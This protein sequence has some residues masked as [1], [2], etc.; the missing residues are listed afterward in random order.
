MLEQLTKEQLEEKVRNGEYIKDELFISDEAMQYD[1][2]TNSIFKY[3]YFIIN[4]ETDSRDTS[5]SSKSYIVIPTTG[6]L[7]LRNTSM[8]IKFNDELK[9]IH[10]SEEQGD[11]TG[12]TAAAFSRKI[13]ELL[14]TLFYEAFDNTYKITV[15]IAVMSN[16]RRIKVSLVA[17][18]D[19]VS[20]PATITV[21]DGD[22]NSLLSILK[23]TDGQTCIN[24]IIITEEVYSKDCLGRA[25]ISNYLCN[26]DVIFHTPTHFYTEVNEQSISGTINVGVYSI[27]GYRPVRKTIYVYHDAMSE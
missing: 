26:A 11:F 24:D 12:V 15:N 27:Y 17:N 7:D 6:G 21:Y 9:E 2:L 5:I 8:K 20:Y 16:G 3:N 4:H 10:I 23:W 13:E 25:P 14:T 1:D 19:Y 22:E 18:K